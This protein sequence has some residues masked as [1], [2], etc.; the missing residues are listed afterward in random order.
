MPSLL[1][2]LGYK[3]IVSWDTTEEEQEKIDVDV[4]NYEMKWY[5][6]ISWFASPII[7]MY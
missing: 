4:S 6:P 2:L 5:N 3:C 7:N 1:I